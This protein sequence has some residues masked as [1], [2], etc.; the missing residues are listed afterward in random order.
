MKRLATALIAT[1]VTLLVVLPLTHLVAVGSEGGWHAVSDLLTR[2]RTSR[3]LR[4][5]L[6]VSL[7]ATTLSVAI[8][9]AAA[10]ATET[11]AVPA[12]RAVRL[13]L[14]LPLVVPQF[15]GAFGWQQAYGERGI[16]DQLLGITVPG[17]LGPVG[18]IGVLTVSNIPLAYLVTA[19]ALATRADPQLERAARSTGAN[20]WTTLRTIT[21]PLLRQPLA[22]AAALV[23][24]RCAD[25]FAIPAVLGTPVGF[26]TLTTVIYQ[27]LTLS[28]TAQRFTEA[29]LLA[30][31]LV[32]VVTLAA[33]ISAPLTRTAHLNWTL[34]PGPGR[35]PQRGGRI[36]AATLW[37][38]FAL[39]VGTP[40]L[41]LV[42]TSLTP[43]IGVT[44]VP[45]NWS[46]GN[47]TLAL[48]GPTA[49]ALGNSLLLATT[50]T[51]G[52]LLLGGLLTWVDRLRSITLLTFALPGSVVAVAVLLAYGRWLGGTLLI[53]LIA[54]LTKLWP[55][56]HRPIRSA[57]DRLAPESTHAAR[58]SGAGP[59]TTFTTIVLPTLRPAVIAAGALVFLTVLHEVT[60]STLLYGPRSQTLAVALLNL[61]QLGQ[62]GAAAALSVMLTAL[63][64]AIATPLLLRRGTWP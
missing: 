19:A 47:F 4:H 55:L 25:A 24:V 2:P 18:I 36:I 8:G 17:L 33:L 52:L 62:I 56:A 46:T 15:V 48:T 60:I 21:L 39:T 57:A 54:Y 9:T 29:V 44:P 10:L 13:S 45:A 3:A 63:T 37:T 41:V 1:A 40:L 35:T 43:A 32:V 50:A 42:L 23:F 12:R 20:A 34:A 53:I 49:R 30:L 31:L 58:I 27:D 14:L 6:E 28:S 51:I 64:L 26:S 5:T 11:S 7:A 38:Y 22:A 59:L 61:Q 16:T